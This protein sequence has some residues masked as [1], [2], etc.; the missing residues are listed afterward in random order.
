LSWIASVLAPEA[1]ILG[2]GLAEAGDALLRPLAE[3]VEAHL[4]FQPRPRLLRACLGDRAAALG[5]ALLARDLVDP[6]SAQ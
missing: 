6:W 1:V 3:S 4:T 2:G 5:S